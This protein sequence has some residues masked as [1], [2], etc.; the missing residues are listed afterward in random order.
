VTNGAY[1]EGNASLTGATSAAPQLKRRKATAG[2]S[3]PGYASPTSMPAAGENVK[4]VAATA[5]DKPTT[6]LFGLQREPIKEI[7]PFVESDIVQLQ[8]TGESVRG[9]QCPFGHRK[10]I[11]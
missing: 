10:V 11:S 2:K 6:T 1:L 5:I 9:I 3:V 4:D 8:E 7:T